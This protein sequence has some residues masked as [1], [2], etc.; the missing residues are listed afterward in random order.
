MAWERHRERKA[1]RHNQ[2][3]E[4]LLQR[5]E[6]ERRQAEEE[7]K[8]ENEKKLR[9]AAEMAAVQAQLWSHAAANPTSHD[10][11]SSPPVLYTHFPTPFTLL[12]SLRR[13]LSA[14]PSLPPII[15]GQRIEFRPVTQAPA[16]SSLTSNDKQTADQ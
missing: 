11:S 2:T 7:W 8:R 9:E 10:A 1:G 5:Y 12:Y 15:V 3:V 4:D 13:A 6:E 14:N 16:P